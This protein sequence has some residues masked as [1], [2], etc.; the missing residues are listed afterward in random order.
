[1]CQVRNI[2]FKI[3]K[4]YF[5]VFLNK[6]FKKITTTT[7]IINTTK[8]FMYH[9]NNVEFKKQIGGVKNKFFFNVNDYIFIKLSWFIRQV[10]FIF[11]FMN[12]I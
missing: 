4:Y 12:K 8:I 10:I 1:M 7:I 3:K 6:N 11:N 9:A 2:F 5:N